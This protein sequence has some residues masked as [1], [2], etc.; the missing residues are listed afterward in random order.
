MEVEGGGAAGGGEALGVVDAVDGSLAVLP[1]RGGRVPASRPTG[2]PG[3]SALLPA[4][5]WWRGRRAP[6]ADAW[7][8]IRYGRRP[9]AWRTPRRGDHCALDGGQVP[10]RLPVLAG[11]G[12]ST[13]LGRT[14]PER[15]EVVARRRGTWPLGWP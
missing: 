3:P 15:A 7:A 11:A 1:G 13:R 2:A 4:S 10:G 12:V 6:G 8:T 9:H 14:P 5:T